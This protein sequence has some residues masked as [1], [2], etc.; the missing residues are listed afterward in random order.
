[1]HKVNKQFNKYWNVDLGQGTPRCL[2]RAQPSIIN[3]QTSNPTNSYQTYRFHHF[4]GQLVQLSRFVY[5]ILFI[6][7]AITFLSKV[8]TFFQQHSKYVSFECEHVFSA[9]Q[10]CVLSKVN[11]FFQQHRSA[12]LSNVNTSFQQHRSAFLSKV[13][14]FFQQHRSAYLWKLNTSFNNTAVRFFRRST[15]NTL[16]QEHSSA[17]LSKVNTFFQQHRS[18][19]LSKVN[20]EHVFSP[21]QKYVSFDCLSMHDV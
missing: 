1:M 4:V 9:T 11:T 8:N 19:F 20:S 7:S 2:S 13:N 5:N 3:Q 18:T 15:V 21:T 17:F 10:K 6:Y 14:T 12:F 16:F